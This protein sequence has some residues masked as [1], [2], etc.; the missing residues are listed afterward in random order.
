M[1]SEGEKK[2]LEHAIELAEY[3]DQQNMTG[4][5]KSE[6]LDKMLIPYGLSDEKRNE[7]KPAS[8]AQSKSQP[9]EQKHNPIES[10]MDIVNAHRELSIDGEKIV[11]SKSMDKKTFFDVKDEFQKRKWR[12]VQAKHIGGD[13]WEPGYFEMEGAKA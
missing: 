3:I 8:S 7:Q 12:Y 10:A 4:N 2:Y 9:A 11:I 6:I 5:L 1:I 13:R